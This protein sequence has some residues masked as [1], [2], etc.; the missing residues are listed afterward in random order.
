MTTREIP[1]ESLEF[2]QVAVQTGGDDPTG[3]T[4]SIGFSDTDDAPTVWTAGNWEGVETVKV[5]DGYTAA[6][7]A[8][9]LIGPAGLSLAEGSYRPWVKVVDAGQAI[10]RRTDDEIVVF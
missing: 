10:V 1:S 3:G 9:F 8:R 4:P 6:Y 2:V 7:I 5:G